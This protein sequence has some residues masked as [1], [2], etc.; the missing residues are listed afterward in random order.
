MIGHKLKFKNL[1]LD[2]LIIS[3]DRLSRFKLPE[4]SYKRVIFSVISKNLIS[5]KYSKDELEKLPIE[6]IVEIF[7]KIWNESIYYIF[8]K[9]YKPCVQK[10]L[11]YLVKSTFTNLNEEIKKLV[12]LKIIIEPIL[13][14]LDFNV[15]PSNLKYL[16][17]CNKAKSIDE[18]KLLII[19]YSLKFPIRKLLI[20]EGITEEILLPVFAKKL[21]FDF[22]KFGIFILGAG[23][24]SKSPALYMELKDKLKIPVVLLF[25]KDGEEIANNLN[26]LLLPKDSVIVIQQGEFEDILSLNLIKRTLN[27]EYE[28]ITKITVSELRQSNRMCENISD[29]YKRRHLGEFKKAKLSKLISENIKYSSDISKDVKNLV[30]QLFI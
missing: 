14:K 15:V 7:E 26:K 12:N 9:D 25:D 19:K 2:E 30:N 6:D 16:I 17:K 27:N 23:G 3:L 29:F 18:I 13:D 22:A 8:G 11:Q 5:P 4:I 20:V 21:G 1:T 28:P 10:S 24:K